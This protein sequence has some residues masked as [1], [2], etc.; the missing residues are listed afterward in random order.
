MEV[1]SIGS[2]NAVSPQSE[3]QQ[4]QKP[5]DESKINKFNEQ[6]DKEKE[7]IQEI[8]KK[9]QEAIV[10]GDKDKGQILQNQVTMKQQAVQVLEMQIQTIKKQAEQATKK[11]LI[12]TK[13]DTRFDKFIPNS[14]GKNKSINSIYQVEGEGENRKIRFNEPKEE[15]KLYSYDKTWDKKKYE[16]TGFDRM[17]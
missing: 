10:N 4:S 17:A 7:K 12:T 16:T 5:V 1:K 13:S 14:E 6:I 8:A 11:S 15:M 2:P 9:A 3:T